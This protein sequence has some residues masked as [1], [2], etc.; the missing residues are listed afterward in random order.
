ML[1]MCCDSA[2]GAA[3]RTAPATA[4]IVASSGRC[5]S[6][7]SAQSALDR[8]CGTPESALTRSSAQSASST[9]RAG[10]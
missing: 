8:F 4:A 5:W 1:E 2:A 7:L 10:A 3:A 9:G 6:A